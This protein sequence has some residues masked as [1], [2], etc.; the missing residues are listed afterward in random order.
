MR[1]KKSMK[2]LVGPCCSPSS[3]GLVVVH[4]RGHLR[5]QAPSSA[6]KRRAPVVSLPPCIRGR[7]VTGPPGGNLSWRC[8]AT[9]ARCAL[10]PS[11]LPDRVRET[12]YHG[13][14]RLAATALS[15]RSLCWRVLRDATKQRSC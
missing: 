15:L 8:V 2:I 11:T 7:I 5:W 10:A 1:M 4:D 14:A 3:A 6:Y 9:C 12:L 13:R